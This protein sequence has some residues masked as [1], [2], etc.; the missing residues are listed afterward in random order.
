M[1]AAWDRF[2]AGGLLL[3]RQLEESVG[4]L[5]VAP[6]DEAA[7][8]QM[9]ALAEQG[10][11]LAGEALLFGAEDVGR[12]AHACEK[13][14]AYLAAEELQAELGI[15]ILASSLRALVLAFE[16]LRDPERPGARTE[17]VS[18]EAA[19]YELETLF[20]VPGKEH[21]AAGADVPVGSLRRRTGD[22]TGEGDDDGGRR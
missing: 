9:R 5:P 19:R 17:G 11:A 18:L 14:L 7:Q 8:E 2:V 16:A 10:R 6:P 21:L 22:A 20:P 3:A 1:S 4:E 15:P 12:L 13:A